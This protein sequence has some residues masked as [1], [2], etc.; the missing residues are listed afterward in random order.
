MEDRWARRIPLF[1]RRV[2][3]I[4]ELPASLARMLE[5]RGVTLSAFDR[6][7][8]AVPFPDA[9]FDAVI[10]GES[11]DVVQRAKLARFLSRHGYFFILGGVDREDLAPALDEEGLALYTAF[12]APETAGVHVAVWHD[13]APIEHAQSCLSERHPEWAHQI[14]CEIPES[15]RDSLETQVA[16]AAQ[17]QQC[18]LDMDRP[19]DPRRQ[20]LLFGGS[21]MLF[22]QI[23]EVCPDFHLAYM[24]QSEFW[25]RIGDETMAARTLRIAEQVAPNPATARQIESYPAVR[26]VWVEPDPPAWVE[27]ARMPRV[28][29]VTHPRPHFGLDALF[30]GLCSV[31]GDANVVEFPWKPLLHGQPPPELAHYPC[32]CDHAGEPLGL[33]AFVAELRQGQFDYILYGDMEQALEREA[34]RAILDAAG[35][36][37]LFLIDAQDECVDHSRETLAYMGRGGAQA[38]FKREM[39]ACVDYGPRVFPLPF[40]HPDA[41]V[42]SDIANERP[43]AFF[44]AGQRWPGLREVYLRTIESVLGE[45][46]DHVYPPGEYIQ[47]IRDARI[48]LSAFGAGFDTVRYYELPAQGC[49]L[50]S[51]PPPIRIPHNFRDGETAVFFEDLDELRE[52]L[53][54]LLAHPDEAARIAHAGHEHLRRHHT[55]SAR[56]RHLLGWIRESLA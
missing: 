19:G 32:A 9:Y 2:L 20:L 49:L 50:F 25:R 16:I 23:T 12:Q 26:S 10:L 52:K 8:A 3:Q 28:L 15:Y 31:L 53:E 30:D 33:D 17:K 4:G 40:A 24:C 1:I 6:N 35:S 22:Y 48:G 39:L 55:A 29:L 44:W 54:H 7:A 14:L 27:P 36:T 11:A 45:R 5:T 38:C 21:L 56:A 37:P 42:A 43:T 18:L 51:E 47:R 46:F 13:Y 41:R 34:A